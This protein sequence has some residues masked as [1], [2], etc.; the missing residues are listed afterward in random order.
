[1][2]QLID[3]L[4]ETVIAVRGVGRVNADDYR[5]VLAP[6]IGRATT[7]GQR[8][9][10]YLELGQG[11][12]GYDASA[13]LADSQVGLGHLGSFERMAVVTDMGTGRDP[14]VRAA[15]PGRRPSVHGG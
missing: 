8:T 13:L 4:P 6:A 3:G 7:D 15:H 10:L 12:E 14:P 2:F 5:T 9:R 1:M 11:F